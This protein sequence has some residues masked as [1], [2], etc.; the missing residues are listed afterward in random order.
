MSKTETQASPR[1]WLPLAM[2]AGGLLLLA[3]SATELSLW[4]LDS[5]T[6]LAGLQVGTVLGAALLLTTL[7]ANSQ[8]VT[9]KLENR[10]TRIALGVIFSAGLALF[11]YWLSSAT[12]IYGDGYVRTAEIV[13]KGKWLRFTEP[14][15]TLLRQLVYQVTHACWGWDGKQAAQLISVGCGVAYFWI[16]LWGS[17]FVSDKR[18]SRALTVALLW[19]SGLVALFF[20]Y[21]ETYP[22]SV[23]ACLAFLLCALGVL[24]RRIPAWPLLLIFALAALLHTSM[25]CLAPAL[26]YVLAHSGR[27][28]WTSA[29]ATTAILVAALGAVI[30]LISI[31]EHEGGY[32]V[33]LLEFVLIPLT[34][35]ASYWLF[36]ADHL[37]DIVNEYLLVAPATTASLFVLFTTLIRNRADKQIQFLLL[38][39]LL[40]FGF[41]LL[42]NTHL[43]FARDWDL[44]A[45]VGLPPAL[46]A[47]LLWSKSSRSRFA[48][49]LLVWMG[50]SVGGMYVLMLAD[51]DAPVSRFQALTERYE[52]GRA[53]NYET[54]STYYT[55]KG[56]YRSAIG[57]LEK[58][59]AASRNARYP[60]LIGALHLQLGQPQQA[61]PR[62][63]ESLA[64][65]SSYVKN[66]PLL[67]DAYSRLRERDSAMTYLRLAVDH[68]PG[69]ASAEDYYQVGSWLQGQGSTAAGPY[70]EQTLKMCREVIE[71]QPNDFGRYLLAARSSLALGNPTEAQNWLQELL[72]RQPPANIRLLG[73]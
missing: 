33:G 8:R 41:A 61:I 4:S 37:T 55:T 53:Y 12:Y 40:A 14:L 7:A 1:Q 52:Q 66:Y 70:F 24:Q 72:D 31:L 2:T 57:S 6:Y 39:S 15:D 43:G 27:Q 32:G 11:F 36:A 29:I 10:V 25:L 21:V 68:L 35:A 51:E 48:A 64:I 26:V 47:A 69:G 45:F 44:F 30:Y 22:T 42:F 71:R 28:R 65:D 23:V 60:H 67:V 50:L 58:A 63:T 16:G 18:C 20:G 9:G 59:S 5:W 73:L 62:L 19:A 46:L 56:Q 3:V 17:K 34:P 13:E 49:W 38:A 54:L